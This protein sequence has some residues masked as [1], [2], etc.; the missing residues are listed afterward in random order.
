MRS[1]LPPRQLAMTT[2]RSNASFRCICSQ[3]RRTHCNTSIISWCL[4]PLDLRIM[5]DPCLLHLLS[6]FLPFFPPFSLRVSSFALLLSCFFS[7]STS[8]FLFLTFSQI[9]CA[10][11]DERDLWINTVN[12]LFFLFSFRNSLRLL[13]SRYGFY[14]PPPP[15]LSLLCRIPLL[16]SHS[17]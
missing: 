11:K 6:S 1:S 17:D 16:F 9:A 7:S 4:R 8:I 10:H 2:S 14:S 13:L 12:V 3:F 5:C 15:S